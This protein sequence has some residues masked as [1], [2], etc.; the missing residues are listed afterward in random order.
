M[1]K[2]YSSS[3]KRACR[4]VPRKPGNLSQ[5]LKCR[6]FTSCSVYNHN[7]KIQVRVALWRVSCGCEISF[8]FWLSTILSVTFISFID[9][10]DS[11]VSWR[12]W[13]RQTRIFWVTWKSKWMISVTFNVE[14]GLIMVI[15]YYHN[16]CIGH[17]PSDVAQIMSKGPS[18]KDA[19]S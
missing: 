11:V 7:Q 18:L 13:G 19:R 12:W 5:M 14:N 15:I 9:G 17:V 8:Q 2:K 6:P 3:K 4:V 10:I 1:Y 16:W